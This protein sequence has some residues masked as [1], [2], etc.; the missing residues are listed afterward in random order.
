MND[1]KLVV[2]KKKRRIEDWIESADEY[3]CM[4]SQHGEN[5]EMWYHDLFLW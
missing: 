1:V 4:F 5:D 3:N 2:L